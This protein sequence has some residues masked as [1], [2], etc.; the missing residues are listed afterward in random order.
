VVITTALVPGRPAPKLVTAEAVQG[1]KPGSVIV[2][3]AGESGGNCEL[4]EPGKTAVKHDVKIVSPL[5][6]PSSMAEHS[7]QLFARNVQALLDLLVVKKQ[8][9]AQ[10]DG[11]GGAVELKLDFDDEIVAGACVVRDGEVVNAGAKAALE[12]NA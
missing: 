11:A 1:M 9:A 12:A 10:P 7:S 2:D 5:N 3:L 6:L 4:T 8:D